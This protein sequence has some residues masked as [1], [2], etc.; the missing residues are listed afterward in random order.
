M[1]QWKVCII[2]VQASIAYR[3]KKLIFLYIN[4][5]LTVVWIALQFLRHW[6]YTLILLYTWT[7]WSECRS[8]W[9]HMSHVS[10]W[11]IIH[12]M[13]QLHIWDNLVCIMVCIVIQ[14]GLWEFGW[15]YSLVGYIVWVVIQFG[16]LYCLGC[17][18]VWLVIL[19]GL[20]YSLVCESLVDDI[21]WLVILFGLWYSLVG[22]IVW[23]VIQFGW[24]YCLGCDTVWFV[25]VWLMI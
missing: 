19:F 2:W 1:H 14:F 8:I 21:V 9:P 4:I 7:M 16:W 23:V 18:T 25:R 17:D 24:L 15:L 5:G 11:S 3:V 22:Y 10:V 6:C 20:W 12:G 13:L